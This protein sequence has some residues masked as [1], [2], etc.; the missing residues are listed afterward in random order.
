MTW[1]G[2]IC[3]L[4]ASSFT[5]LLFFLLTSKICLPFISW[6]NR[7]IWVLK[8]LEDTARYAGLLLAPAEG[9]G[10]WPRLFFVIWARREPV[11]MFWPI[12]GKF[13][14]SVVTLATFSSN[15]AN[16]KKK[17]LKTISRSQT[18]SS[19]KSHIIPP[20]LDHKL[21]PSH[22]QTFNELIYWFEKLIWVTLRGKSWRIL[23]CLEST[24]N[25]YVH[26]MFF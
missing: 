15:L 13:G 3:V 8:L 2:K 22:A 1:Y 6:K 12:L 14:Y 10:L 4:L 20:H 23:H 5:L 26:F 17:N 24:Q 16:L 11:M 25:I 19:H 21:E 7:L 18:N 9:F